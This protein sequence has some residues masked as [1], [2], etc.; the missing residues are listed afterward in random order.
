MVEW[1]AAPLGVIWQQLALPRRLAQG[2]IDLFWSPLQTLPTR[3]AVPGVATIH[4]LAVLLHPDTLPARVRWSQLPLLGPTVDAAARLI[5]VSQATADDLV[6]AFPAAAGKLE[7]IA[8]GV[9]AIWTPGSAETIAATRRRLGAPDGYLLSVGTLEPRKNLDLLLDAWQLLH[10]EG[11]GTAPPLLLAGSA[12]WKNRA[13]ERRLA[14]LEPLGVRRLGRLPL[15]ELVEVV[16]AARLFLYPSIYEGFGLPVAEAMAAGVPVVTSDAAALAEIVGDAGRQ[17]DSD[18]AE[19]WRDAIA[20]LWGSPET[21]AALV[22]RAHEQVA[23]FSWD[24]AARR[25]AE[26]FRAV[27]GERRSS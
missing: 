13:L 5:A 21:A 20:D 25:H 22:T 24:D 7:V 17:V 16:R 2:D 8:N 26:L 9:G 18:D 10:A 4:D 6:A 1:Q 23:R 12:G 3:M 11:D 14:A 15:G 19:G 27:L